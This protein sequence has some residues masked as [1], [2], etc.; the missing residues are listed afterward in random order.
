MHRPVGAIGVHEMEKLLPTLK[1]DVIC[2][3]FT[4]FERRIVCAKVA[5]NSGLGLRLGL[6]LVTGSA[7]AAA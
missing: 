4:G 7:V 6:V 3:L 2:S 1:L 5:K